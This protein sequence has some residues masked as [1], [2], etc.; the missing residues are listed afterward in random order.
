M[1][2]VK[3][4]NLSKAAYTGIHYYNQHQYTIAS[5]GCG[6]HNDMVIQKNL[7]GIASYK[8]HGLSIT[9]KQVES[10]MQL[11]YVA[12]YYSQLYLETSLQSCH[13]AM[14]PHFS[15]VWGKSGLALYV[16]P[17]KFVDILVWS[18][19]IIESQLLVSPG[20]QL[21]NVVAGYTLKH[22]ILLTVNYN[23]QVIKHVQK[24]P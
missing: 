2:A 11:T 5:W 21:F 3:Q 17:H 9:S 4:N 8:L 20:S 16:G 12:I 7:K 14:P 15:F 18:I 6:Y 24:T 22:I 19:A 23:L 1:A 10:V 13:V